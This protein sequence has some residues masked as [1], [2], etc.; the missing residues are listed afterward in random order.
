MTTTDPS[1]LAE[2]VLAL[3]PNG[4]KSE[5]GIEMKNLCESCG[6]DDYLDLKLID[7]LGAYVSGRKAVEA[8]KAQSEK[9]ASRAVS[10]AGRPL[11][12]TISIRRDDGARTLELWTNASPR[13]FLDAVLREQHVVDG[14]LKAN[15][16]RFQVARDILSDDELMELATLGEVCAVKDIDP[17]TLGL[18]ELSA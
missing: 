2:S 18:D 13:A 10:Y 7:T 14:R 3:N 12:P 1:E 11:S 5:W 15:A 6:M 17:D 4:T 8:R 9:L 16:V